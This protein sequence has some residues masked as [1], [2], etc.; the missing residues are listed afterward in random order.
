MC[1]EVIYEIKTF[2]VAFLSFSPHCSLLAEIISLEVISTT[3]SHNKSNIFLFLCYFLDLLTFHI[4]CPLSKSS[5][6][7]QYWPVGLLKVWK[8]GLLWQFAQRMRI[9]LFISTQTDSI[10]VRPQ[11]WIKCWMNL[12]SIYLETLFY[13]CASLVK[14]WQ[15]LLLG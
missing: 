14:W 7:V 10:Q 13:L 9:V 12:G 8:S 6:S 2:V 4:L 11:R 1:L 5:L 15:C 3:H